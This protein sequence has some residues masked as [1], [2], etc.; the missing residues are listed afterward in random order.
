[1]LIDRAGFG[2]GA[3]PPAGC[4]AAPTAGA[5]LVVAGRGNNGADGR[6]AAR[7]LAGRGAAVRVLEAGRSMAA[8]SRCPIADLVIDAAYGTGLSRRYAPPD[9]GRRPVLAVD[10]PSGLSGLTGGPR[11]AAGRGRAVRTV[12][13]LTAVRTVTFA[14]YKPGLLIGDGPDHAGGGRGRRHRARGAR[15][16]TATDLAGRRRATSARLLPRPAPRGAQVA[17]GGRRWWPARR[18]CMARR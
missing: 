14:A 17:D 1:M 11:R 6:L 4:S 2:R 9:P 18:P 3:A 16:R 10:I 13:A 5:V 8:A 12:A 7:L 15:A